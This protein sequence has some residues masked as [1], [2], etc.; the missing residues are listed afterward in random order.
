MSDPY[1]ANVALLLHMNGSNGSTTFTD[2]SNIPKTVTPYGN[3]QI[4]TAQSKFGGSSGYFDG[5]GDYLTLPDHNHWTISSL[6]YTVEFWFR[7]NS[8]TAYAN[9]II[10]KAGGNFYPGEWTIFLNRATGDGN[11][12][13]WMRDYSQVSPY[14]T[15]SSGGYNDNN[16][17]HLAWCIDGNSH[18][19]FLDGTQKASRTW[20]TAITESSDILAIGRD[21]SLTARDYAG[22]LQDLRISKGIARYTAAFTAPS[23]AFDNPDSI[24]GLILPSGVRWDIQDGGSYRIAGTA[25]R[26]GAAGSYRVRLFDRYDGRL[27]RECWSASNGAFAFDNLAYR[28]NRYFAVAFDHSGTPL[29][30]AIQDLISPTMTGSP[31]I[32]LNFKAS[33]PS[34][35][36]IARLSGIAQF[37]D[38]SVA[39]TVEAYRRDSAVLV[40]STTPNPAT[41]AFQIDISC[42][43]PCNVV[44][45]RTGYRPLMH[46]PVDPI[47]IL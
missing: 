5:S 14:L 1:S 21:Y 16:W 25:A 3:A 39:T 9:F 7:S 10:R 45:Y 32:D 34:D 47:Q 2:H 4:S 22:Y 26:L 38:G 42:N 43:T 44:Q 29:N 17:H 41:G 18:Y 15:S 8:T 30:A 35:P 19:L 6:G 27:I 20:T 24:S 28:A 31:S 46:G 13:I 33:L 11:P 36:L 37:S 40:G 23:A 12:E